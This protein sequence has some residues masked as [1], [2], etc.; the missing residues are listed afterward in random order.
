MSSSQHVYYYVVYSPK[1]FK[2]EFIDQIV[3]EFNVVLEI[4]EYGVNKRHEHSNMVI[5][6]DR[7]LAA[8]RMYFTRRTSTKH[9]VKVKRV[10]DI[11]NVV[12]YC[13]KEA[14]HKVNI[15]E[16][17]KTIEEYQQE[18]QKNKSESELVGRF[19]MYECIKFCQWYLDSDVIEIREHPYLNDAV[20][21]TLED[22]TRNEFKINWLLNY[23]VRATGQ[24]IYP[25]MRT[26]V[27]QNLV[28]LVER[29]RVFR[30]G[31]MLPDRVRSSPWL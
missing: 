22:C 2:K 25:S 27:V 10:K 3:R 21:L 11:A 15:Y 19:K 7:T 16:L 18:G 14:D 30:S 1:I 23:Y 20:P 9:E 4:R 13:T 28:P 17:E 6:D 5:R 31:P 29:L 12:T 26:T 24:Y 8:M